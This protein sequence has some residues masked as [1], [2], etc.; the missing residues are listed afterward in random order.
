MVRELKAFLTNN[1]AAPLAGLP[2][3]LGEG[4]S[5]KMMVA[6]TEVT[7]VR[8]VEGRKTK[9]D[10]DGDEGGKEN[11]HHPKNCI[12]SKSHNVA[13]PVH[14]LN[15]GGRIGIYLPAERKARIAKFHSKRR[16]R[17]WRK[18]VEYDCRKKLAE[19]KPRIKGRFA[20]KLD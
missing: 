12:Y 1:A 16:S 15:K 7:I 5:S 18:R 8:G 3:A 20:K 10:G 17:V 14:L 13:C 4:E 6:T 9:R 11:K 19:S 2:N